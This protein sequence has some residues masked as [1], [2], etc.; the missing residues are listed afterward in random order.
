M[1]T[2]KEIKGLIEKKREQLEKNYH[3]KAIGVFGSY[4]RGK[5]KEQSD[6]DM[7]VDFSQTPDF[8]KFVEL[9]RNLSRM[10]GIKVDLVTRNALKSSIKK[11]IL[12]ETIFL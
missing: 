9:E 12:R 10:L 2:L 7:L 5:A 6:L 11:D 1:K 4:R 3:I 8:F